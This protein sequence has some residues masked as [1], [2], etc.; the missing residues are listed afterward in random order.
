MY[1]CIR[2]QGAR[3]QIIANYDT[4]MQRTAKFTR[5]NDWSHVRY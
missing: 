2:T 5:T 1:V 3:T 4:K